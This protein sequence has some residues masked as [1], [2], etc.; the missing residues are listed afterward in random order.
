VASVVGRSPVI[1]RRPTQPGDVDRT[2]ADLTRARAELGYSPSTGVR[3]GIERQYAW[4]RE[5]APA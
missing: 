1:D 4:M 3:A 5:V 2:W